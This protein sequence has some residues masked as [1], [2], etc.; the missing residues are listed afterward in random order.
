MIVSTAARLPGTGQLA[1]IWWH[2]LTGLDADPG[3]DTI[4]L[5]ADERRDLFYGPGTAPIAI[6]AITARLGP[7]ALATGP[8]LAWLRD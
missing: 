2:D 4:T 7:T 6:A 3:A 1:C 8:A 5:R